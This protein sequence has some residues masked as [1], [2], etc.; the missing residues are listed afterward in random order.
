MKYVVDGYMDRLGSGNAYRGQLS[1]GSNKVNFQF[2]VRGDRL[3]RLE[4]HNA[5]GKR[6]RTTPGAY[7]NFLDLMKRKVIATQDS[8]EFPIKMQFEDEELYQL[9]GQTA[10]K[11]YVM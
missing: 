7:S 11:E 10:S 3:Q 2:Q 9:V 8:K 5:Q 4:L 6:I 1:R